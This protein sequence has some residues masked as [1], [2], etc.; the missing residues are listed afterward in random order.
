MN[1]DCKQTCDNLIA[2]INRAKVAAAA[3]ADER[4][5]THMQL[6]VLYSIGARGEVA[7]GQLAH[8]LHCDASNVTGIVDRLVVQQLVRRQ[9]S[10]QDRRTKT[11]SLTDKGKAVM[12][13]IMAALPAKF[14]CNK[15]TS[16]EQQMLHAI[17]QKLTA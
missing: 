5:M 10:I 1:D 2:L 12:E 11:L 8:L 16:N 3:V 17:M 9:E 7:M 6:F 13:E 14:G 4:G 15:L